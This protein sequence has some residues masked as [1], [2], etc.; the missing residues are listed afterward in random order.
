MII[1]LNVELRLTYILK[2][3]TLTV[4]VSS[5]IVDLCAYCGRIVDGMVNACCAKV[6]INVSA[7]LL[8]RLTFHFPRDGNLCVKW[9]RALDL[10]SQQGT[11]AESIVYC[12]CACCCS[13]L[14]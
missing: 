12:R 13:L 6:V 14:M 3:V 8:E 7:L 11:S 2:V 1:S 9:V 10:P 5:L 4:C